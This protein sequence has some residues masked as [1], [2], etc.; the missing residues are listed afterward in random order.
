MDLRDIALQTTCPVLAA[1]C[2]GAL[3][4]M[5]NGQRLIVAAN[6]L[7]VQVKLDWLDCVHCLTPDGVG[8][9]LP[10]GSMQERLSFSFGVLPIRLIEAF[11]EA[12]RQ[13]LPDE[14]AGVLIYSRR[15][16][17]LR[18]ALCEPVRTSP[19]QIEYR[20]PPLADDETV[21][22][23]LH[24]H[25]HGAPFWSADDDRDDQGIKVA[26]VFGHL[27]HPKPCAEF[28]LVLNGLYK[29]LPHPWQGEPVLPPEPEGRAGLTLE[30]GTLRR[31]LNRWQQ[32]GFPWNI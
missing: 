30:V 31:I 1:P 12:G 11:I 19:L 16:Q 29:A 15:T 17:A 26:G 13:G 23:D 27:H 8:L 24:T 20:V 21:A 4:D 28:R 14:V 3:P 6:G 9:P 25:G 18:L 5:A 10:F 32:R 7:F 2:F 22:V